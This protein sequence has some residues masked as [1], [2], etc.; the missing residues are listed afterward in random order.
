LLSNY[1][2]GDILEVGAGIGTNVPYL[3]N[4]HICTWTCL[5]PDYILAEQIEKNVKYPIT[6]IVG[7]TLDICNKKIKYDCLIYIDVLEHIED[8][9]MELDRAFNLLDKQGRIILLLPAH[10]S[11][12]SSFD[13]QVGHFRRYNK[14]M[15][16]KLVSRYTEKIKDFRYLDSIGYFLSIVNRYILGQNLPTQKQIRFW[17]N[18]IISFSQ[19]I[20]PLIGYSFGKSCL[21][22]LE[23]R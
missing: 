15:I 11:L 9:D 10:Q 22:V 8:D 20:D 18:V 13:R 16:M 6:K 1:L 21:V 4:E 2:Y 19:M 12:Y 7:T 17:N 5:E 3:W 14:K 23:T